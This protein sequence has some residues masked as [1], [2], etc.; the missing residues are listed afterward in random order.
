[1]RRSVWA[2]EPGFWLPPVL[3]DGPPGIGKSV[4]ARELGRHLGVPR[5][6]IEG[7]AEQ[8]SFVVNGSQRGWGMAFPGRPLQTIMQS[9]CANQVVV[10]DEIEK[11][12]TPT[13]TKGQVYGLAEE[14]L[15]M[16][17]RS[18]AMA[19]KCPYF[20]IGFDM[21]WINWV[22][23][24]NSLNTLPAPFLSRLEILRLVGPGKRCSAATGLPRLTHRSSFCAT[25][26]TGSCPIDD[27]QTPVRWTCRAFVPPQ[28]PGPSVVGFSRLCVVNH[29]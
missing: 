3:L 23:T 18:S 17:E 20:Q 5:C 6:G 10:I 22:L 15:P 28:G 8:A 26:I 14:L 24:S 16:L 9:L 11:A 29:R 7:T 12:G 1:M 27:K 21:S 4:W 13:S 25:C 19:W 2:G